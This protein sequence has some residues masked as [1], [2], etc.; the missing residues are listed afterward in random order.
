M[1]I[2]FVDSATGVQ[3]IMPVTPPEFFVERGRG[4]EKLTMA[5]AGQLH[6]PGL[7]QLFD[8]AMTFV[9]P[10]GPR[11]YA[12]PSWQGR[13]YELVDQ[14]VNWSEHGTV[15]RMIITETPVNIPVLLGPVRYGESG[16]AGDV[17]AV[18]SVYQYRDP[19]VKT[20]PIPATG[21][22]PRPAPPKPTV[23]TYTVVK[24]DNLWRICRRHYGRGNLAYKL[25]AYNGIK[26]ANLIFPGQV[27]RLPPAGQL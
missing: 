5:E 22:K 10:S 2:V 17:T 7:P 24:G 27:L 16:G 9:L 11:T 8:A 15:L 26:N 1:D 12:H 23:S 14:L 6:L 21:N 3:H 20:T 4:V 13:P 19:A 18:L 25:A